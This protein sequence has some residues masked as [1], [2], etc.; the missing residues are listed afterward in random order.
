MPDPTLDALVDDFAARLQSQSGMDRGDWKLALQA[1]RT[2]L[3]DYVKRLEAER[4]QAQAARMVAEQEVL[5]R[6]AIIKTLRAEGEEYQVELTG[7][8]RRGGPAPLVLTPDM[9]KASLGQYL[10]PGDR[11]RV[12]KVDK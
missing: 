11:V 3:T 7:P 2:A 9:T 10:L 4:V 5:D 1:A 12:W 8:I 6:D